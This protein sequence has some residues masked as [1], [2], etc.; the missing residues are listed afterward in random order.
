MAKTFLVNAGSLSASRTLLALSQVLVLPV[1]ARFLTP[2]EFGD[3]AIAM[4]VGVIG[5]PER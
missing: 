4:E 1:V 5:P 3:M 2:S